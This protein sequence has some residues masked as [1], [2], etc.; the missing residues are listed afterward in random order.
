MFHFHLSHYFEGQGVEE[1]LSALVKTKHEYYLHYRVELDEKMKNKRKELEKKEKEKQAESQD[2]FLA[3]YQEAKDGK[4]EVGTT[5]KGGVAIE[6][7]GE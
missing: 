3:D 7:K 5:S 1:L 4:S 6:T 2:K